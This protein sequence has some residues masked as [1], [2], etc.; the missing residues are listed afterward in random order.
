MIAARRLAVATGNL[1]RSKLRSPKL[2]SEG[3]QAKKIEDFLRAKRRSVQVFAPAR[4][5]GCL[6]VIGAPQGRWHFNG[7][8]VGVVAI[9]SCCTKRF[10]FGDAS[11]GMT[12]AG[13]MAP[14]HGALTDDRFPGKAYSPDKRGVCL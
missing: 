3:H 12:A 6:V 1:R 7:L 13:H 8:I 4:A 14:I 5:C 10:L 11:L 2:A 9:A